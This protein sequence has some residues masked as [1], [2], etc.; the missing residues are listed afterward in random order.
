MGIKSA[1]NY[2]DV[3]RVAFEPFAKLG[4]SVQHFAMELPSH[5]PLPHPAFALA[6]QG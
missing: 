6:T 1:V 3:T 2:D 5:L 4:D